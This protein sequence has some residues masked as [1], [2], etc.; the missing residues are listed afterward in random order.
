MRL[1]I[2]CFLLLLSGFV[3]GEGHKP[4]DFLPQ[5]VA[6]SDVEVKFGTPISLR[7]QLLPGWKINSKAPSQLSVFEN[8][9][10]KKDEKNGK[11]RFELTR[12]FKTHELE[13]L[14]LDLPSLKQGSKYRVQAIFYTCKS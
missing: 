12:G 6:M 11:E 8:N 13:K 4:R 9:G 10:E 14:T 5:L 2:L 3:F 1:F 7:L